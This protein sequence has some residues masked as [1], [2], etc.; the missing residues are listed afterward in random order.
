MKS[1]LQFL[2]F[3]TFV[4]PWLL[5]V[6]AWNSK[7]HRFQHWAITIFVTIYGATIAIA[8]DPS[9]GRGG[10]GG[11]ADG[12]DH[13]SAVYMHYVGLSFDQFVSESWDILLLKQTEAGSVDIFK[14]VVSY[15]TGGVLGIP[16]LFFPV[17]ALV[18]GYFFAGS[19]LEIFKNF[20]GTQLTYVFLA[21]ALLFFLIKNIEGVNTVRTWTGMWVLVYACLKYYSTKKMRYMLLMFV[22]PLIHFGY[23][24]MTIPAWLVLVFG[25]RPRIYAALFV[26]SSATTI[27]NPGSV[28]EV[29]SM[30][31]L[32]QHRTNSYFVE[33]R[34]SGD[35]IIQA[36]QKKGSRFYKVLERFGLQKWA[37]NIFVYTLLLTG[38]YSLV[39]N[40]YQKTL[41]SIGLLTLTLSNISWYLYAVS[42]RSWIIG[43]VFIVAAFLIARQDPMTAPRFPY[44]RPAYKAG[45]HL[46]L[47]LFIPYYIYNLSTLLDFPSVFLFCFPFLIFIVPESNMSIKKALQ[48]IL[49]FVF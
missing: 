30:S 3:S 12:V 4:F 13:L 6:A 7:S 28:V 29:I 24:I 37:L 45:L 40:H 41:F 17:V 43:C 10:I 34:A 39:M 25:S 49:G 42:Q 8:Y 46:S 47:L 31:E 32:G 33:Q 5:L 14:H 27:F 48:L 2:F 35:Q 9:G 22:P 26:L 44:S 18:Y 16:S 38:V 11:N 21:F 20:K 15:L 23:F 36:E 19:I 1:N